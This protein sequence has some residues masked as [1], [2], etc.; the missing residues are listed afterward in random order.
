ML[1]VCVQVT[2]VVNN[3]LQH[4]CSS[5]LPTNGK[6]VFFHGGGIL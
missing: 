2:H 1:V 4:K 5:I 6:T 3:V